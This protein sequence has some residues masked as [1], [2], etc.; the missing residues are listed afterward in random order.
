MVDRLTFET[1][2]A[3]REG[4][5]A[6]GVVQRH[7]TEAAL[8]VSPSL[9]FVCTCVLEPPHG[10]SATHEKKK[11]KEEEEKGGVGWGRE[12]AG[13]RVLHR[14]PNP[15]P[16]PSATTPT[17]KGQEDRGEGVGGGG[18]A[19]R[20]EEETNEAH[21]VGECV[22]AILVVF[23]ALPRLHTFAPKSSPRA[24]VGTHSPIRHTHTHTRTAPLRL[25][26]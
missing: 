4:E 21:R 23:S 10:H 5:S 14:S 1:T 17:S 2:R 20:C 8:R 3:A 22:R 11:R 9:Y 18:G 6:G 12:V 19:E 13:R 25:F 26:T 16:G 15:P 24:C 7:E